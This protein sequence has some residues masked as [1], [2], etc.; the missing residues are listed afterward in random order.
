[1]SEMLSGREQ[2]EARCRPS[3]CEG[4]STAW[5][6]ARVEQESKSYHVRG[7]CVCCWRW[8][9]RRSQGGMTARI[10]PHS[11]KCMAQHLVELAYL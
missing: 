4:G 7:Y 1:M 3:P 8:D 6:A 5:K 2:G 9:G 10:L 11:L